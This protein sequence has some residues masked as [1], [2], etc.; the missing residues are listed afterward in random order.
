MALRQQHMR[1]Q[2]TYTNA[3]PPLLLLLLLLLQLTIVGALLQPHGWH[4]ALPVNVC[5]CC[6]R[7]SPCGLPY[8]CMFALSTH[9]LPSKS[10]NFLSSSEPDFLS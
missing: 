10:T 5:C 8:L 7:C 3:P 2:C 9:F 6:C 1:H 4:C